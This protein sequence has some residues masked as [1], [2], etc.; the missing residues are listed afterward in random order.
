MINLEIP[1]APVALAS[2]VLR[3]IPRTGGAAIAIAD[4][5]RRIRIPLINVALQISCAVLHS[6][7]SAEP[8]TSAS[9]C[10]QGT[11]IRIPS[12]PGGRVFAEVGLA[13]DVGEVSVSVPGF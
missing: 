12:A 1:V 9:C 6:R 8:G 2:T 4:E 3:S 10:L 11:G 7:C 13:P 5:R